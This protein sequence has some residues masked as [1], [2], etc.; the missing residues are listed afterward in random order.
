MEERQ[1]ENENNE[2]LPLQ[3]STSE[4]NMEEWNFLMNSADGLTLYLRQLKYILK[5]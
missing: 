4:L 2:A 5:E 1:E 3:F